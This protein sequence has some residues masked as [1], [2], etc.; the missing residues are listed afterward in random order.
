[1]IRIIRIIDTFF[2]SINYNNKIYI[3]YGKKMH[4]LF[5]ESILLTVVLGITV[6]DSKVKNTNNK[7]VIFDVLKKFI[8]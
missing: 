8:Y 2:V 5:F 7:N 4:L 6:T 3:L 1:M